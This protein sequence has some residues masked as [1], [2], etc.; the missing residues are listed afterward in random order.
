MTLQLFL[1][2]LSSP[3]LKPGNWDH[4]WGGE[5]GINERGLLTEKLSVHSNCG[6]AAGKCAQQVPVLAEQLLVCCRRT[7]RL[8][9]TVEVHWRPQELPWPPAWQPWQ[10]CLPLHRTR[11]SHP[12]ALAPGSRRTSEL[13][14]AQP[15]GSLI[16]LEML[17]RHRTLRLGTFPMAGDTFDSGATVFPL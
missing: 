14:K 9:H 3:A 6:D 16:P 5:A 15:D 8:N 2:Q 10:P 12:S 7:R 13:I 17:P 4:G 1:P 11:V